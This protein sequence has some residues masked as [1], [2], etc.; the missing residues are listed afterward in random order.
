MQYQG[1]GRRYLV[2]RLWEGWEEERLLAVSR[3]VTE[4][5]RNEPERLCRL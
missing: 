3:E 4:E 1:E 5:Q 2:H